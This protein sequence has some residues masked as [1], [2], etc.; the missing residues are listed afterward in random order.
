MA[1]NDLSNSENILVKVD[2][3]NLIYIDPNSIVDND[4][5]VQPRNF[6]QE[7]LVMYVNLEADLVPRSILVS[8]DQGS[9]LTNIAKGN[10]NFLKSQ[11]GD[12]DFDTS[13]TDSFVGIP[14]LNNSTTETD[15]YFLSDKSGQNFGIDSISINIKG[16]NFIPQVTINFVDV[17]GKVL[18]ESDT[19]ATVID[20]NYQSSYIATFTKNSQIA[21]ITIQLKRLDNTFPTITNDLPNIVYA[22]YIYGVEPKTK[23]IDNRMK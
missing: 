3:N 21:N 22:F 6:K 17:R 10:L 19:S 4:G 12:G 2:Q 14:Q 1:N 16:A 9:T 13:Y 23:L 7:N 15:D 5:K 18:F 11:T 20:T 8:K